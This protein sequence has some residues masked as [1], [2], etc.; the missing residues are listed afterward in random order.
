MNRR[1]IAAMLP[2]MALAGCEMDV[3]VTGMLGADEPLTGSMTQYADG[4]TIELFGG[5]RTHCVGNFTY[6]RGKDR[7]DG[8]GTL[9]CDDRRMGPFTFRLDGMKH[10]RGTGS[11][12]GVPY[13]FS[14]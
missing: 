2:M 13:R 3:T 7:F 11:L 6:G 14:F 9:V 12:S 5:P 1:T 4:G 10:G 8:G